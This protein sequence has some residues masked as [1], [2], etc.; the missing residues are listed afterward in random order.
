MHPNMLT[1]G[2]QLVVYPNPASDWVQVGWPD[3]QNNHEAELMIYDALGRIRLQTRV[4][5][6]DRINLKFMPSGMYFML[7]NRNGNYT[8]AKLMI[9]K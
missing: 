3:A 5:N 9:D 2:A 8:T 7:V 6:L 1:E 4:K